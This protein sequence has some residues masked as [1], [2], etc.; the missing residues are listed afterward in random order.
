MPSTELNY[1]ETVG[2]VSRVSFG[3]LSPERIKEKAVCEIY[4]HIT[5]Q[6][7]LEGTL[8][9]RRLGPIERGLICPTCKYQYKECPGH[10]GYLNLAK[11]VIQIQYYAFIIKLLGCW[12]RRCSSLLIDKYNPDVMNELRSKKGKGRYIYILANAAKDCYN[13]GAS[14]PKYTKDKEGIAKIQVIYGDKKSGDSKNELKETINAETIHN[15]FK[16]VS[17]EDVELTGLNPKRSRP[18]WMIWTVM[19]IPPP[20]MRP[21]VRSETGKVSDDDL[22]HK[23]NDIIKFNNQLRI[24]M[25][26]PTKQSY[27]DDWWQL[28]QYHCATYIDNEISNIPT[29]THRSGRPLKTIRQRV[30]AKEGRVRGNLMGKR[31]DDSARSVITGDPNLSLDELGVPLVIAMN[32]TWPEKVHAYNIAEMTQLV[33]NGPDVHPGAKSYKKKHDTNKK[34]LRFHEKRDEI[35]LEYGD[36]VYR[37][38]MNG[39]WVLFNRQPSL[40]K[41]SMMGHRMRVLPYLTFRINANVTGPYNADFDGDEMNMHVP[42]SYETVNEIKY[43]ASVATQ[44]IS[45]QASSPVMGM[46]QDSMVGSYLFTKGAK[47]TLQEI[48]HLIGCTNSYSGKIPIPKYDGVSPKW[49]AQQMISMFLPQINYMKRNEKIPER[50]I[51]I[52]DGLMSSGLFDKATLGAKNGSLFHITWND[53]GPMTTLDLFNNLSFV[54]NAW[55]QMSGFSVGVSDCVIKP[56]A[57]TNIKEQIEKFKLNAM[58]KIEAVNLGTS[59]K[60]KDPQT[61]KKDFPRVMIEILNKCR[62]EAEKI[63]RDNLDP[64]NSINTMVT[65]GSKGNPS[66]I[67]Q[68]ISMLGQQEVEGSWIGEQ[69]YRRTL[70]HFHKDCLTPE[71]HGF[72]ENSF[73]SGLGPSE[74][75]FHAAAGR[76]GVISKAIKTAETG[77]IQRRLIK[78]LEDLRVCYD[79]TVRNANNIIIQTKY[80]GDGFDATYHETQKLTFLNYNKA[81]LLKEFKHL[82]T[83]D[84]KSALSPAAYEEFKNA[85]NA[86]SV[87]D[88]EFDKIMEYH[89]Y[90]RTEIFPKSIPE[91]VKCPINMYRNVLNVY[92]KFKLK[93]ETVANI[94]PVYIV[95]QVDE[96]RKKLKVD[97][98]PKINYLSTLYLNS[99]IAIHLS[100]KNLIYRYKFTKVAFDY[101]IELI[102]LTFTKVLVAPGENVG[103]LA[104]QSIGEPATQMSCMGGEY[105][106]VYDKINHKM[107]NLTVKEFI[108]DLLVKNQ[109]NVINLGHGSIVLPN[110]DYLLPSITQQEKIKWSAISEISRHPTNGDLIKVTTNSGRSVTTTKSHSFLKRNVN[111][112][113]PIR[114]DE[115]KTGDRIPVSK[116]IPL[117]D[118]THICVNILDHVQLTDSFEIINHAIYH[119]K[120]NTKVPQYI[121][122]NYELGWLMGAY[123]SQGSM[124]GNIIKITDINTNYQQNVIN[125][126]QKYNINYEENHYI[127]EYGPCMDYLIKDSI[128]AKFLGST[129]GEGSF[130]KKIPAFAFSSNIKFIKGIIKGYMDGD[131]SISAEK[132]LIRAGSRSKELIEHMC[133]LLNYVGIFASQYKESSARDSTVSYCLLIPFK[134]T[135]LY[136]QEIG[137]DKKDN[138]TKLNKIVEYLSRPNKANEQEFIDKIPQLGNTIAKIGLTLQLPGQSRNYGR[139]KKKE[140]I[141]RRTLE[142]YI[143]IFETEAINKNMLNHIQI[144]LDILKQAAESDVIWDEI[145]SI[146]TIIDPKEDV[147]DFSVPGT[148]SFMLQSGIIVHNTLDA[149]HSTG[150]GSKAN[151]SRGVPRLRELLGL[152]RNPK[153]PVMMVSLNDNYFDNI[154]SPLTKDK[155]Y[156]KTEK[157][158]AEMEYT[159][160]EDLLIRT[161]IQYDEDDHK[162]CISE[163]QEFVDSYYDLLPTIDLMTD[164][165]KS[166]WLIRMEFNREQIMNKHIPLAL[167]ETRLKQFLKA[168][169]IEHSVILSDVNAHKLICRIKIDS[170]S[171]TPG[172]D[173]ISYMRALEKNLLT[174]EIKGING[175][176][177]SFM[178]VVNKEITLP[179]GTIISPFD[180]EFDKAKENY[181]HEQFVIDTN[182]SNLIDVLNL[183]NVDPTKTISN[184]VWE[185]YQVYGIEAARNCLIYEIVEVLEYSGSSISQRH[186]D[187]LV[188]VMTNQGTLVSV[189]R[190]GVNK[191]DS[192]PLHRAS[193][194]E[195][196]A[197]I[198]NASIFN[199][200]D[201][202]T[203]VS[204][205]IMFGQFL[206]TGTNAF[207]IA[208][209]PEKI[210]S[211]KP[212]EQTIITAKSDVAVNDVQEG[213]DAC[214]LDNFKFTFK[215][216][217]KLAV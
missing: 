122:L 160:L 70:P 102:Y 137:S 126:C 79:N 37:H 144:D 134:Y 69:F 56:E 129:C 205:N 145:I 38:L 216:N 68:L 12:C 156:K 182:G 75:W 81:K 199:E 175:I 214:D 115:L 192:G 195:T 148:E 71:S 177:K 184:N 155:N 88:S 105:I 59:E 99:L 74:Y 213:N 124:K 161:E 150:L 25:T 118:K 141:G 85:G 107:L 166:P 168:Y 26:E 212:I 39:D 54:V 103:I 183:P 140:S 83:E 35:K 119:K 197:Q 178:R 127:G 209:D 65:S 50:S 60:G 43:L 112:I 181:V 117:M 123:C 191:T 171:I 116:N 200:V 28:V 52:E 113:S 128:L 185:V 72:I 153:A 16:N 173:P 208:I 96:L 46:V 44:V 76:V 15:T 47:L 104:A 193:F 24:K 180:L 20:A 109:S 66:N 73:M 33:R 146:E 31:V 167:I 7:N 136:I 32:L 163:D 62:G 165:S 154:L 45:P 143:N 164:I 186:I 106:L 130:N 121:S 78:A 3:I 190:H 80:G 9:D 42:K 114:G 158:A 152:T 206:P 77:Y 13:C 5:S 204:G 174:I 55:L 36:I 147:Y 169:N 10:F 86:S 215:L 138:L 6:K 87:M 98:N 133:L 101:L 21:S 196:T 142:K 131:G 27:I 100:S 49:S 61:I 97:P 159:V 90:L 198:T 40:H 202:M 93:H 201:Q 64:N 120:S 157:I 135:P 170:K 14:Q 139:W 1:D 125:F 188:D 162:T 67:V 48:L 34:N 8:S 29:A 30:K 187:L 51:V 194:E 111:S 41:M 91:S 53:Y 110:K 17:D 207:R 57:M 11:P 92:N 4:K 132:H 210:K 22:T 211:M 89:T 203:G 19:P 149:F 179:D 58:K 217:T 2:I 95:Q 23:L 108:D 82:P 172:Q 18:E 63:T 151:V 84:I 94:N 189:D 176:D